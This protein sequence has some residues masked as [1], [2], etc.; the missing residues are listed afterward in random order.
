MPIPIEVT[1]ERTVSGT[2]RR[3]YELLT[4]LGT[5]QDRIW[6]FPSQ[7]FMRSPGPLTPG[8]TEEWH[9][10][11]HAVLDAVEPEHRIVWRIDTE[12]VEGSHT[13][14]LEAEGRRVT[15]RHHLKATLDDTQ[16]RLL[17]KRMQD[18]HDRAME[19]MFDKLERVLK[20]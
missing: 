3:I 11:L 6:P 12:G 18:Q 14:E 16:G 10:G 19:G 4:E 9:G 1:H 5:S 7:P 17:W 20:R 13:F 15:V 8:V 2:T